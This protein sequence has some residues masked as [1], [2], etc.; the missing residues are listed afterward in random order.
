ME[1]RRVRHLRKDGWQDNGAEEGLIGRLPTGNG[2]QRMLRPVRLIHMTMIES[3]PSGIGLRQ[4]HYARVLEGRPALGFVEVH[5]ENFFHEGGASLRTLERARALSG[6]PA[7][8][9][10]GTRVS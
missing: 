2:A 9:R 5:S 3:S 4:P 8:R 7:R 6:Q 10:A 1:V